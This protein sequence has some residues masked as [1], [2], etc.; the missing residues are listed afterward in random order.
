MNKRIPSPTNAQL[1]AAFLEDGLS[2]TDSGDNEWVPMQEAVYGLLSDAAQAAGIYLNEDDVDDLYARADA[3]VAR[4][5]TAG[6][7]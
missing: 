2:I 3:I 7:I 6:R 4:I 5:D 1:R